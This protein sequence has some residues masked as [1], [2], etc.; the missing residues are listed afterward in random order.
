VTRLGRVALGVPVALAL[1]LAGCSDDPAPAGTGS[2]A[3]SVPDGSVARTPTGSGSGEPPATETAEP[4]VAATTAR[5]VRTSVPAE[6]TEGVVVTVLRVRAVTV[7][8]EQPGQVAG[9]AAAVD[10]LVR[11]GTGGPFPVDGFTVNATTAD[12]VALDVTTAAPARQLT[13]TVAAGARVRGT[14]VFSLPPGASASG[15]RITVLSD[16]ARTVL[17]F[18]G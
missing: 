2:T 10:L 16:R 12:D 13:G 1:L 5:P 15:L 18:T 17:Q 11:N 3:G 6:L 14:Y 8:A 7:T 9:R 4:T